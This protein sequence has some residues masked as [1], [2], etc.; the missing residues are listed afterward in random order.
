VTGLNLDLVVP[1]VD[2]PAQAVF[3]TR[4]GGVSRG[5][6]ASLNLGGT[7]ADDPADVAAN[8]AR[9]CAAAGIDGRRAVAG[10]QVHGVEVRHV[11]GVDPDGGFLDAAT[12]WP[13][14]DALWT[15]EPRV[16][17][18]V[19]GADCLPI[20]LWRRDR[21]TVAAV[22]AGWR[23]LVAG[24]VDGALSALGQPAS[25]GAA[26]GPGIG[27]CCY[28][29]SGDVRDQ[30]ARRFGDGVVAGTAVDLAAAARMSLIQRGVA[31]TAVWTLETC[32]CCDAA[33]WFSFRRDGAPTGRQAGL[34]WA[35]PAPDPG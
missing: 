3:T 4:T 34:I 31:P 18:A 25:I 17:L 26:I 8:R 6:Y 1:P 30:F 14:C 33:R 15:D 9:V 20:L 16:P 21:P 7:V 13:E 27:P 5:P 29:V 12:A 10:T 32:T 28:P 19:F 2:G 11:G 35:E 24:I 22:H 23:G